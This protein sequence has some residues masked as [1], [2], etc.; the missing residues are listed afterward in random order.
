LI[1]LDKTQQTLIKNGYNQ[2]YKF[3]YKK[4]ILKFHMH[5]FTFNHTLIFQEQ[6]FV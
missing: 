3:E 1:N 5:L 2:L 4:R 6:F